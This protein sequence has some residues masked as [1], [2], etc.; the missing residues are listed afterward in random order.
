MKRSF[1]NQIKVYKIKDFKLKIFKS[2]T[3]PVTLVF[4]KMLSL[5]SVA[6]IL[7]FT[8]FLSESQFISIKS[9]SVP[10]DIY[11]GDNY[12][13]NCSYHLYKNEFLEYL[14]LSKDNKEFY[15]WSINC[16]Y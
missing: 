16:M 12:L 11:K 1:P 2:V 7:N 6:L 13:V 10:H 4:I 8:I 9:L 3:I 5:F 15:K 14:T